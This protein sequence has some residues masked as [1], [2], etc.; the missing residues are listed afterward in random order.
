MA[1]TAQAVLAEP[2]RPG[3]E[4]LY[5]AHQPRV[6]RTCLA[7]LRNHD[8]AAEAT[9]EVFSRALPLLTELREPQVWLTTVA[10]N[11][12]FDQLRRQKVR[13]PGLVLDEE[14]PGSRRDDPERETML[15]DALRQAFEALSGRERRAL[16]RVLLMDD[17]LGDIAEMLGVSYGA[18]A[19]VVSRARR[20]AALA[21]RAVIGASFGW[22]LRLALPGQRSKV[23]RLAAQALE[24]GQHLL[25]AAAFVLT[26]GGL[27][28][29]EAVAPA[30]VGGSTPV[31]I[32]PAAA[33]PVSAEASG[34]APSSV[35]VLP[36]PEAGLPSLP[37]GF[38]AGMISSSSG[39]ATGGPG[40]RQ[41]NPQPPPAV[42]LQVAPVYPT[43]S[44]H[45]AGADVAAGPST[46]P[47]AVSVPAVACA[48]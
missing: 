25:L 47:N 12:C 40:H 15:R 42:N 33:H 20:R 6:F 34:G 17:S 23:T 13:G 41:G 36:L 38:H 11:L 21:A 32:T 3:F 43:A 39:P 24:S 44:S 5:A 46:A 7:I 19:Q 35:S 31:P 16:A 10:R 18:A 9:Q 26:A 22:L 27:T 4:E 2:A 29:A 37:P 30:S 48:P 8:D 28:H 14:T 1:V 45:C